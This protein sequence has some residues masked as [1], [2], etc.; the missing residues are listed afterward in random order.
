MLLARSEGCQCFIIR[1]VRFYYKLQGGHTLQIDSESS[2]SLI[3]PA[4]L[5]L[6]GSRKGLFENFRSDSCVG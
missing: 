5:K 3:N 4:G 2:I 1:Q 6:T